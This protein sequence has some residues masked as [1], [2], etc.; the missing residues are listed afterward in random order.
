MAQKKGTINLNDFSRWFRKRVRDPLIAATGITERQQFFVES[1]LPQELYQRIT[2]IENQNPRM[3]G[4]Q[5]MALLMS[6]LQQVIAPQGL[7]PLMPLV[8]QWA[9]QAVMYIYKSHFMAK[10]KEMGLHDWLEAFL[11]ED[12]D[13]DGDVGG[14]PTTGE[15]PESTKKTPALFADLPSVES[16][17]TP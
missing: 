3:P 10:F 7:K 9:E 12:I 17:A 14:K 15:A 8:R 1:T 11:S 5:K 6:E 16:A 2:R 13:Q 4:L